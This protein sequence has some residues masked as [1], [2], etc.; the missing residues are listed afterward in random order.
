MALNPWADPRFWKINDRGNLEALLEP[1]DPDYPVEDVV[2][3]GTSYANGEYL[4]TLQA[5]GPRPVPASLAVGT[6]GLSVTF[7][8]TASGAGYTNKVYYK[9]ISTAGWTLAGTLSGNGAVV[10]TVPKGQY[11]A[12]IESILAGTS[13]GLPVAFFVSAETVSL[14]CSAAEIL[15]QRIIDLAQASDPAMGDE[16][17]IFISHTPD[18]PRAPDDLVVVTDTTGTNDGRIART[19]EIIDHPGVQIKTRSFTYEDGWDKIQSITSLLNAQ[20]I[21]DVTLN[22]GVYRLKNALQSGS[23]LPM[24][25]EEGTKRRYLFSVNYL[26]TVKE[27]VS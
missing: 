18:G 25:V 1:V 21:V 26:I 14:G 4:G 12:M 3:D 10:L 27:N 9:P 2:L 5:L 19:G 13:Q 8:V 6:A 15:A 22:G 11:W 24:G 17:P 7:T 16:W 23:I 20:G